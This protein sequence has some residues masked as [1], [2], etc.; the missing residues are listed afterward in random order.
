VDSRTVAIIQARLRSSRLP[1]KILK[2]LGHQSLIEWVVARTSR[3]QL[4][5][6]FV[7]ATTTEATD[8]PLVDYC[9]QRGWPVYRGPEHDVLTRYF[10]A[11][12]EFA[13]NLI[14]RITSDCP[15][16]DPAEIDR[17]V[18]VIRND[19]SVDYSCNFFPNRTFPR[20]LDTECFTREA[21]RRVDL[22]GLPLDSREHVTLGIYQNPDHFKIA[23]IESPLDAA[24]HRWTVDTE[25][26]YQ[27]ATKLAEWFGRDN[28]GW[29]EVLKAF[30]QN[31][32]WFH[33]NASVQQ[34]VLPQIA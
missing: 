23:G 28:F 20:G 31:P 34:K 9:Q 32:N 7:I 15:F 26:D 5:D 14:V 33:I 21:L 19:P 12:D 8:D 17:V 16:I 10:A 18:S 13:A 2:P 25:A 30:E 29:R 3:A 27:L 6:L 22:M 11:A 24:E 1:G 4:V